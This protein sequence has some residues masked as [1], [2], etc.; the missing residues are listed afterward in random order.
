MHDIKSKFGTDKLI[1]A[2]EMTDEQII[3]DVIGFG[4]VKDLSELDYR[5]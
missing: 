4:S 3:K 5:A 1:R 2:I